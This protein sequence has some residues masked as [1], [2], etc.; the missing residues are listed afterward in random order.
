MQAV[1]LTDEPKLGIVEPIESVVPR[2]FHRDAISVRGD[3]GDRS[4]PTRAHA[5]GVCVLATPRHSLL[6]L[7]VLSG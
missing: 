5:A 3:R 6:N 1:K 7:Y 2:M 4:P